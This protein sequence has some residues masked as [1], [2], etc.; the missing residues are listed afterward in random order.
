MIESYGKRRT[1]AHST[2]KGGKGKGEAVRIREFPLTGP[3]FSGNCT[4]IAPP[5]PRRSEPLRPPTCQAHGPIHLDCHH[6]PLSRRPDH[7]PRLLGAGDHAQA[8]PERQ[9]RLAV[10]DP[11]HPV[12]RGH[13]LPA[14]R[15]EPGGRS[16]GQPA[17]QEPA[18]H[19][20]MVRGPAEH[21]G[22]RLEPD[23]PGVRAHRPADPH[24]HRHSDHAGQPAGT[25]RPGRAVLRAAVRRCPRRPDQLFSRIL[26][27]QPGRPGRP[28]DHG[29]HRGGRP[30]G[31]L[32]GAARRHRRQGVPAEPGGGA[33]ANGRGAA[34]RGPAGG[35]H[36]RPV[37]AHRP[38]QPPK[39][40][41][42][43]RRDRLHR[44]PEPG[45]SALLQA[46]GGRG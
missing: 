15:R 46:G 45:R 11:A 21:P 41:R 24:H 32:P 18:V 35:S 13:P 6:Q 43:R 36:P 42:D 31:H 29:A 5:P 39:D 34:A 7:P 16:A 33:P 3:G 23:Q 40:R 20:R 25:A 14:V 12:R 30:R 44:Q 27:P 1:C 9:L 17:D 2:R 38:A 4:R 19:P 8:Q 37:R 10:G 26:H 22:D 28:A